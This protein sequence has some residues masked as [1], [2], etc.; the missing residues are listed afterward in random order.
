MKASNAHD[1]WLNRVE[2]QLPNS[3]KLFHIQNW[4][5]S[6]GSHVLVQGPSGCGKTT[7]LHLIAGLFQPSAGDVNIGKLNLKDLSEARRCDLRREKIGVVF[8]KLNL[9]ERLTVRENLELLMSPQSK[10]DLSAHSNL[11]KDALKRV[12]MSDRLEDRCSYLSLGEQQRVAVARVLAQQPEIILADEP[13][14]SL[15]L[16]NAEFVI[17]AL[18]DAA[19][20]RTLIVVSHDERIASHFKQ[21]LP[22]AEITA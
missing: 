4:K 10:N 8:Q 5:I 17:E 20:G 18:K 6:H 19:R 9:L 21:V 16:S 1:V 2:V 3:T 14:S 12:H 15:D 22:F 7:L 13:T 11:V